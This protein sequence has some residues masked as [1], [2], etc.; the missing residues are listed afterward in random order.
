MVGTTA[1]EHSRDT[2]PSGGGSLRFLVVGG[3]LSYRALF[4]WTTPTMYLGTLFGSPV[5]Q[6]LFFVHV[7]RALGIA[8]DN[9]FIVGNAV[10]AASVAGI[11]GGTMAVANERRYGTLGSVLLSPRS[12]AVV[13]LSRG[14]PY[15]LNGILVSAVVLGTAAVF[16]GWRVPL[17]VAA[18]LLVVLVVGALS[19]TAFGL[20]LGSLGLRLRD[21]FLIANVASTL[22]LVVTGVN[23]PADRLPGWIRSLGEFLPMTHAVRAA[24]DLTGGA[25]MSRV[26]PDLL[27]E[28]AVAVSCTLLA[29]AMLR[30]FEW[31]GRR[32]A[33]LDYM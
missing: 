26:L 30:L 11:F 7:G 8:D 5:F 10:L 4:N 9:F 18:G 17:G 32:R 33:S 25:G 12:R 23:V 2:R 27:L 13:F 14:L 3:I 29:L 15:V 16:L 22:L 6:L 21:V 31:E 19:C 24:R 1:V 20:V 28:L